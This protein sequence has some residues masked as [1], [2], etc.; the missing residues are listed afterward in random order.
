MAAQGRRHQRPLKAGILFAANAVTPSRKFSV[1]PLAA[2]ARDSISIWVSRL[3][4]VDCWNSNLA[5]PKRRTGGKVK[6]VLMHHLA[7][8]AH[9]V[10]Q[11]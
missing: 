10:R 7:Y 4:L 6:G 2:M 1:N 11:P 3:S 5:A 9:S 8:A